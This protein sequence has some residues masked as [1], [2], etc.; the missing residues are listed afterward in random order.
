MKILIYFLCILAAAIVNS[1]ISD[2]G[3]FAIVNQALGSSYDSAVFVGLLSA[4]VTVAVYGGAFFL[5]KKISGAYE[6]KQFAKKAASAGMSVFDYAKSIAPKEIIEHCDSLQG[7]PYYVATSYIDDQ[8]KAK[9]ISREC[10]DAL[11]S[12]YT[13][14]M[15]K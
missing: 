9:K 10:A 3:L 4:V 11:I 8:A 5:A 13:A 12:G 2:S 15:N 6:E 7:Q 14:L 1:V